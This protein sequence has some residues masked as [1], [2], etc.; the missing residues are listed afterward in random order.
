MKLSKY[1]DDLRERSLAQLFT[2]IRIGPSMLRRMGNKAAKLEE[3]VR[4]LEAALEE[5]QKGIYS[6]PNASLDV[7]N[8][9]Y[10]ITRENLR[11]E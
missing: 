7:K 6:F 5:L 10:R 3:R 2:G 8:F 9:V 4:E 1:L 11:G